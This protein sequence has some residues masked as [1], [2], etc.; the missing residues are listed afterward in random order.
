M[1]FICTNSK[2]SHFARASGQYI[3]ALQ[4]LLQLLGKQNRNTTA[5]SHSCK[6]LANLGQANS[7]YNCIQP[8]M[9]NL[10]QV[11]GNTSPFMQISCKS[12]ANKFASQP[13]L[14]SF[15]P[16]YLC[17]AKFR[18]SH[19]E[20]ICKTARKAIDKRQLKRQRE[21]SNEC[22]TI[23]AK[24]KRMPARAKKIIQ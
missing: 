1:Q 24:A 21:S 14:A 4:N 22:N 3:F 10:S 7:Q 17:S 19:K 2:V 16:I 12:W 15:W 6:F 8:L 5:H 13:F 11:L 23:S 9:Q 20:Y 18:E